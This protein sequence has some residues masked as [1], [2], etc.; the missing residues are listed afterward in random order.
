[1]SSNNY[2]S[3][4]K[5][6]VIGDF[7]VN[8]L[9]QSHY[10]YNE[11]S[12]LMSDHNLNQHVSQP[13]FYNPNSEP[14]LIDHV[15]STDSDLIT[16][17]THLSP[18]GACHHSVIHCYLNIQP[19]KSSPVTRS[20]W[21]YS[22]ADWVE[23]N[24]LLSSYKVNVNDD[25]NCAWDKF[26]SFFLNVI[27]Q[28]VPQKN[29]RCKGKDPPWLNGVLRK[30]CR[31]KHSLYNKW[32]KCGR[33]EVY[34]KYKSLRNK[35]CNQL[36]HAKKVFFANLLDN[37]SPS[38]R[39]WG[40]CKS[41]SGKSPIPETIKHNGL[42]STS[43]AQAANIFSQFFSECFNE[44]DGSDTPIPHY[45]ISSYISHCS[46]SSHD[47]CKLISKLDNNS[48]AGV[49]S[50]TSVMLKRTSSSISPILSYL[51]NLSLTTGRIPDAWKLSRV[52]PVFKSGDPHAASNYRPISLQPICCKLLEKVIHSQVLHHLNSNNI[53]TD[54]QFGFLPRSS[55]SDA[56]TTA[57]H[58]WYE[59]LEGRKCVAMALFDLSKAFDRVPHSPLL[60]KLRAV[61]ITGPL[62]SWFRSYLS[63]RSQL[64]AVHGA[65][66]NP[67][68]VLSGVPQGSVL[69]PLLFLIYV[70][71]LC[72]STFS[73]NSSLVLYADDT[74]LYKPIIDSADLVSFQSD[75]NTIHDWFCCNHLTANASKTKVMV[76]ST[77]KDPFPNLNL[78]LNN[79]PIERV[80]SAKFLGIWITDRLS[81]NLHIE[82]ICSKARKTIGFLHRSFQSAPIS[83]RRT[84][85]LA[86]VRPIL[87]YGSTTWHP[88][89][90]SLTNRL[91]STQ[92][93]ACRVILQSW[94]LSHDDLLLDTNLPL[95]SKRRDIAT[96]CHMYKILH[97]LCS[98]PNPY[99]PHPRTSLRNLNSC[100][101]KPPFCRLTLSQKSF[102]PYAPTLWNYL[103]EDIVKARSLQSFK[104]AI[105][106]H[107][108]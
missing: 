77:K 79:Q 68:P 32:K 106:S 72:L 55:T 5:I 30:L 6:V 62:L 25:I 43:S 80:S 7:N 85:Y 89:N 103:P 27:N 3:N 34:V 107:L 10:L 37:D 53:L 59:H 49:D 50:I 40:Y 63:N 102:Y 47:V 15:Y 99:T 96:L 94:N 98:S 78:L 90:K 16:K 67:V 18:L 74:T 93:F 12:D 38:K 36:K 20:I 87:E 4:S 97:N 35:L 66:S 8:L 86:L 26:N 1:M 105:Q 44:A 84:L 101:V 69:G 23:A 57:L 17:V 81:W 41:R 54:R 33:N 51:F 42:S 14:S 39:F 29:V 52:I 48:A 73:L 75:I 45:E 95:L 56:L 9:D 28:C 21:V 108:H 65:D 104:L 46:C 31:K 58:D 2:S 61:G 82:N 70:N 92:R 100:A 11:V 60:L 91:E 22:K 64:V 71:D 24:R 13:T 76:I 88:L 19:S 83:T